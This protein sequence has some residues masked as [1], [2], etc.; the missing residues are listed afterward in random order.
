MYHSLQREDIM[1]RARPVLGT[2]CWPIASQG[3][4]VEGQEGLPS[5]LANMSMVARKQE[6]RAYR[7]RPSAVRSF[8]FLGSSLAATSCGTSWESGATA[9]TASS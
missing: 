2:S 1:K 3:G 5:F 9:L 4:G 8:F 6:L 7:A